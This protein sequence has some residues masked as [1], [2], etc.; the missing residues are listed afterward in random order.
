MELLQARISKLATEIEASATTVEWLRANPEFD[1]DL[2]ATA[3]HWE[4]YFEPEKERHFAE[5][6]KPELE[7]LIAARRFSTDA[8]S[9][10]V[11]QYAKTGISLVHGELGSLPG[12]TADCDAADKER[13]L[14]RKESGDTLG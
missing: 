11:L 13:H 14:A 3:M 6:S 2:Q 7:L 8:Q 1:D 5:K 10:S 9:G 12:W 4:S